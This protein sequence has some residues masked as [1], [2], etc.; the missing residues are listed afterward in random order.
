[1]KISETGDKV[2]LF[3]KYDC[4]TYE[5][6]SHLNKVSVYLPA[7]FLQKVVDQ[8]TVPQ[9]YIIVLKFRVGGNLNPVIFHDLSQSLITAEGS[10]SSLSGDM[11]YVLAYGIV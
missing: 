1:M 8:H 2:K 10:E 9:F 5:I 6:I 4:S 7:W 3:S 11:L